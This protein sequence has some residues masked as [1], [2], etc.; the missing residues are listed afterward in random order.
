M[1]EV[2]KGAA[3]DGAN[4]LFQE[5]LERV[6]EDAA[7]DEHAPELLKCPRFEILEPNASEGRVLPGLQSSFLSAVGAVPSRC[8]WGTL[9]DKRG[10]P[11][12]HLPPARDEGC[13]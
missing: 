3:I 6:G 4:G 13:S 1:V 11:Q 9:C 7:V 8:V 10:H 2:I 5:R 12:P